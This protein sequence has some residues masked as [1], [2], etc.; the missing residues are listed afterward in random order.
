MKISIFKLE[1][2]FGRKWFG[3]HDTG[4]CYPTF[5]GE[6]SYVYMKDIFMAM[7]IDNREREND[8]EQRQRELGRG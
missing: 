6:R 7:V 1:L 5:A 4:K 2:L 3:F 8:M